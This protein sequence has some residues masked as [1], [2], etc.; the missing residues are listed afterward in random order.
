MAEVKLDE[1]V[2]RRT[3]NALDDVAGK[4]PG[5][6]SRAD[7]LDVGAEVAGLRTL[8]AWATDTSTDLSARLG[9]IDRLKRDDV[10][11]SDFSVTKEELRQMAGASMPVDEQ[12]YALAAAEKSGDD[13]LLSWDGADSFGD[14]LEQ[15]EVKAAKQLP[16]VG[17]HADTV[18]GL[19]ND[20]NSLVGTGGYVATAVTMGRQPFRDKLMVQVL[21]RLGSTPSV[22]T[23]IGGSWI[24]EAL[25][26]YNGWLNRPRP[27]TA[28]VP[29][30]Q[31]GLMRGQIYNRILAEG[32]FAETLAS[33]ES[34]PRLAGLLAQSPVLRSSI[35]RLSALAQSPQWARYT[36]WGSNVMGRTWTTQVLD[37]GVLT[38]VTYA[39]NA[40]NLVKVASVDGLTQTFKVA[41]ALRVVGIAGGVFATVDSGIS[42]GNELASGEWWDNVTSGDST[43]TAKAIGD[44]AEFGFNASLTAAMI[45]PNPI[46]WGAVGVTGV[47]YGGARLVEHWDDVT[48]AMGEAKDWAGDRLDDVG[49]FADDVADDVGDK[50]ADTIG[51]VK[52]SKLN[53]GNWF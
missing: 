53:P 27:Y 50:V 9:L 26:A 34:N 51:A 28:P 25:N 22:R 48:H 33:L 17:P 3:R 4:V 46:T 20:F 19:F 16:L 35:D 18:V 7:G 44:V 12:L 43:Q 39:R 21:S 29:G 40:S 32:S 11:F 31:I 10:S 5:L 2:I 15:I 14:W 8:E 45:A 37:N 1:G 36:R 30:A 38:D 13:D 42:L 24:D 6:L 47:V 49:D 41:G 52:D 23:A